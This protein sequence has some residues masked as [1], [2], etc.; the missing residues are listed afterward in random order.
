MSN[1]R[2]QSRKKR[3]KVHYFRLMYTASHTTKH[4]IYIRCIVYTQIHRTDD[5]RHVKLIYCPFWNNENQVNKKKNGI[6]QIHFGNT[7]IKVK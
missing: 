5:D 1:Q 6:H 7:N 3:Q 4:N 2:S